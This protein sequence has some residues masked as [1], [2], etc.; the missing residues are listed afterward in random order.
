MA[1]AHGNHELAR[2]YRSNSQRARVITED[3]VLRNAYCLACC[4]NDLRATA[5]NT[6]AQD[7]VCTSCDSTYELKSTRR[8]THHKVV[9]GAYIAMMRRIQTGTVPNIML[10]RYGADWRI[11]SL[12]VIHRLFITT[13]IVEKRRALA[14]TARRAGWIGC[15]LLIWQLPP[16]AHIPVV[17]EGI[18]RS[19]LE[20][21]ARYNA[22]SKLAAHA[23]QDIGW[24]GQVLAGL[25]MLGKENFTIS[26]AYSLAARLA[27]VYPSNRN[28][29]EKI[30]QQLQLLRDADVIV[31]HGKGRYCFKKGSIP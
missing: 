29:H 10:L 18:A 31:F 30:R 17:V 3:W 4:R 21:C 6:P 15:N 5:P 26:D 9:D 13:E 19:K 2:A 11:D 14:E 27:A 12:S 7:F 16:E 23:K 25:R 8:R 1:E 28:I 20:T 24:L 22:I